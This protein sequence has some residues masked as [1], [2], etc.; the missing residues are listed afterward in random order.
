MLK[1]CELAART[2]YN[3]IDRIE[4]ESYYPFLKKILSVG[5]ES[6]LEHSTAMV[7]LIAGRDVMAEITRHRLASFSIR[8][9]RYVTENKSGDILFIEPENY[10]KWPQE[11]REEY[12]K[13]CQDIEASY[14]KLKE[15]GLPNQDARKVLNNSVATTIMMSANLREWRTIFNLRTSVRAYPE[16]RS[17]MTDLLVQ[18]DELFPG[19]FEDIPVHQEE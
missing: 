5:H 10:T 9:Q 3:S 18:M 4:E 14:R 12:V 1:R 11:A 8:S 17:L 19:V 15:C 16:M 7:E 13:S 6:P 2:C